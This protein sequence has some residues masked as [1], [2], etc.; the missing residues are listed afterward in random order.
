MSIAPVFLSNGDPK[1]FKCKKH[2]YNSQ[3]LPG[4][5]EADLIDL[6]SLLLLEGLL[7]GQDLILGLKVECLLAAG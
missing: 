3:L 6:D 7:D 2:A 5:D 1:I 4:V